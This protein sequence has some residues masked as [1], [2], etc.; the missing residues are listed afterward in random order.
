MKQLY[1]EG[2]VVGMSAYELYVRNAKNADPNTPPASEKEW[3]AST[4]AMG[5]SLLLRVGAGAGTNWPSYIDIVLPNNSRLTA[6]NTIM[7]SFFYGDAVVDSVTENGTGW[8]TK[9]TDYGPLISNT[10]DS[11]PGTGLTPPSKIDFDVSEDVIEQMKEYC[12]IFDGIAYQQGTWTQNQ[13]DPPYMDFS[14][15][16][17]GRAYV[18]LLIK[19]QI[20]KPFF[21][22]F[23]GFTNKIVDMGESGFDSSVNSPAPQDGDFLGPW[24]FPWSSKIMFS[25]SPLILEYIEQCS[26]QTVDITALQI[27]NTPYIYMYRMKDG[28]GVPETADLEDVHHYIMIQKI[29][30][31]MSQD[32]IDTYCMSASYIADTMYTGGT[33]DWFGASELLLTMFIQTELS[34]G[35]WRYGEKGINSPYAYFLMGGN[36]SYDAPGVNFMLV[37]VDKRT[38]MISI[39]QPTPKHNIM[40][41]SNTY[42]SFDFSNNL[43]YL[44]S[45][46]NGTVSQSDNGLA[47]WGPYIDHPVHRVAIPDV[48]AYFYPNALVPKPDGSEYG[49]DY[50]S[51]LNDTPAYGNMIP[52]KYWVQDP[53][54]ESFIPIHDDYKKL[55]CIEFMI[56]ASQ[57]YLSMPYTSL[58]SRQSDITQSFHQYIFEK[59]SVEATISAGINTSTNKFNTILSALISMEAT[60][61]IA[62]YFSPADISIVRTDDGT[63][64]TTLYRSDDHKIWCAVSTAK[65][66]TNKAISLIDGSGAQLSL[67]GSSSKLPVDQIRWIDLLDALNTNKSIDVLG[68]DLTAIKSAFNEAATD[69]VYGLKKNADGSISLVQIGE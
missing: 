36:P 41:D 22:L 28:G 52:E 57:H 13:N 47:T 18:R 12:K 23:T 60:L 44:G 39:A 33:A 10:K 59:S 5:S 66:G 53:D 34:N 58:S 65:D 43:D 7:A 1:N 25:I 20:K 15:D 30:G 64:Y 45:W 21:I 6:A 31:Y 3:L 32:F 35:A 29:Y 56:K 51:W 42:A 37:P 49:Y 54:D 11:H 68:S 48:T 50:Y 17:T 63:D 8:A 2:R 26:E 61:D 40:M 14:A 46:W 24:Q 55:S 69:T 19:E 4:L 38:G 27:Y 9:V 62:N 16:M 67:Q